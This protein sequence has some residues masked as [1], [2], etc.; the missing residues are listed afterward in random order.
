MRI[1]A[2]FPA[3]VH[4]LWEAYADPRQLEQFWGPVQWPATFIRHD[5]YSGGISSYYMTGPEGEKSSGFW[6][7]LSVDP[8]HS[9]EVLDGFA[10]ED[11]TRNLELPTMRMVFRFT[12]TAE[13][14]RAEMTT[15]F[16]SLEELESLLEMGMEEGTLSAMSQMDAVIT[17]A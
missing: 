4:R 15:Y 5:M 6:E 9:F 8:G 11:G 2:E 12:E 3:P 7:F 14:S 17:S 10:H 13:G 16:N 1:E